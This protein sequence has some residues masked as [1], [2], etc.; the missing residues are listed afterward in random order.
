M[1]YPC[2]ISIKSLIHTV[3]SFYFVIGQE[4]DRFVTLLSSVNIQGIPNM[5]H[6]AIGKTNVTYNMLQN[7]TFV[8]LKE[9]LDMY[10]VD[11]HHRTTFTNLIIVCHTVP[12][13]C[14]HVATFGLDN[15]SLPYS[16]KSCWWIMTA[17]TFSDN[18]K[19]ITWQTSKQY[20]FSKWITMLNCHKC[21]P[22]NMPQITLPWTEESN[23]Y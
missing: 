19:C 14:K 6:R 1:I 17:D 21:A 8:H 23:I 7:Y 5:P 22:A 2:L 13:R 15:T 12:A 20:M 9:F 10:G 4:T 11:F 18:K 16:S 3:V